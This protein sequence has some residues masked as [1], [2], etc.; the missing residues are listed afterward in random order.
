M[1]E[2]RERRLASIMAADV[3]GYS[4]L[5][6]EDEEATLAELAAQRTVVDQLI[7]RHRGRIFHTAGDSVVAE[8]QSP[9]EAVRAAV[10]V[11]LAL[12]ERA[13]RAP[14]RQA[15]SISIR[16]LSFGLA[17]S[18][19]CIAAISL[20]FISQAVASRTPNRRPSSAEEIPPLL[21]LT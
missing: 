19:A 21:W 8:F 16:P 3:A 11:Q 14:P 6:G 1:G 9:V 7:D 2:Q 12:H 20:C 4:R 15:S 18:R 17:S 13:E 10:E 5:V